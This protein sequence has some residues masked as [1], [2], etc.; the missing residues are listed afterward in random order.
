MP[1]TADQVSPTPRVAQ[2]VA[3]QALHYLALALITPI[4]TNSWASSSLL[5]QEGGAQSIS[6]IMDW[7]EFTGLPTVSLPRAAFGVTERF[8]SLTLAEAGQGWR[9]R[10]ILAA[11]GV[12]GMQVGRDELLVGLMRVIRR[13]SGRAWAVALGWMAAS[14]IE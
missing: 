4:I 1:R 3:L 2:I 5:M 8:V 11:K 10:M 12:G 13:D 9:E 6:L 7:R 14:L